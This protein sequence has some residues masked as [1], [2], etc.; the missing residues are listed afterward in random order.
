MTDYLDRDA[1]ADLS[2]QEKRNS[3]GEAHVM[4]ANCGARLYSDEGYDDRSI[5]CPYTGTEAEK[6]GCQPTRNSPF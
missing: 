2:P 1:W 3:L 6:M 4:C 5:P